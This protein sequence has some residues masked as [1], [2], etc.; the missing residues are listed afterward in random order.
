[1]S[2]YLSCIQRLTNLSLKHNYIQLMGLASIC[3]NISSLRRLKVLGL[4]GIL[5]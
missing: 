2:N 1:M 4:D 3:D 5:K